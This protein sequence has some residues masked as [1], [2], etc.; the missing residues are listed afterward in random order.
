MRYLLLI[1]CVLSG[2]TDGYFNY[3]WSGGIDGQLLQFSGGKEV[4]VPN[5][6]L[7]I[8]EDTPGFRECRVTTETKSIVVTT[9]VNGLFSIGDLKAGL[10]QIC[11]EYDYEVDSDS[12]RRI[13]VSVVKPVRVM[14]QGVTNVIIKK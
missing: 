7:V 11:A 13:S 9:D 6:D 2:F 3:A 8:L 1:L 14:R 12:G 4:P 5:I 10:Y